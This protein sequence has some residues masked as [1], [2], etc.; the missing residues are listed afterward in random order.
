MF[1]VRLN[2]LILLSAFLAA[3]SSADAQLFGSTSLNP[4]RKSAVDALKEA[5]E[6]RQNGQ[7][8][9]GTFVGA[10]AGG[11]T[12]F[13][14]SAQV[15]SDG[16]TVTSSAVA[17]LTEQELPELNV[18]RTRRTSGIYDERLT[19]AFDYERR[20]P[21]PRSRPPG[22][23]SALK[24]LFGDHPISVQVE[25][26]RHTARLTGTVASAELRRIAELIVL[27]E[28]G[29]DRVVNELTVA[30]SHSD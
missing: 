24:H 30:S 18:P 6:A 17:G 12:R 2:G 15:P 1:T 22:R 11:Q 16:S 7:S 29:I 21:V 8:R 4:N 19:I 20:T 9:A 26:D 10:G 14:G 3:G 28:P 23:N 13:V 27:F 25:P 5:R